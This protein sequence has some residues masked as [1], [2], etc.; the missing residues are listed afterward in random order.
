MSAAEEKKDS[1]APAGSAAPSAEGGGGNKLVL[2][3]TALNVALSVGI[4]AVLF[5]AH[6]K[7]KAAQSVA[8]IQTEDP[9]AEAEAKKDEHGGGHGGG[10]EHG[11]GGGEH[12]GAKKK[13]GEYGEQLALEQFTANLYSPGGTQQKFIRVNIS[14]ELATE[15]V[16]D[17][18]SAKM[19]QV[20]NAIFDLL[21]SKRPSDLANVEGRDF[22]REEI[23]NALNSFLTS[24]K[25]K[26]VYFTNFAV[27]T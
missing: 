27:T 14:L 2:I 13:T 26:A 25:V 8:D 22:L 3:L 23:R 4:G 7:E 11:G 17:E 5:I 15:E 12:G 9:H 1:A 19:P 21:N 6:K 18:V 16:K 10:G 20:R 24:G